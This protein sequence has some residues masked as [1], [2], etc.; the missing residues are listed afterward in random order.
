MK[1]GVITVF[2]AC[3]MALLLAFEMVV[4]ESAR[5]AG[6]RYLERQAGEA[7]AEG[8]L[9]GYNRPLFDTFGLL[10]YEGGC[11]Q[12]ELNTEAMEAAF[13]SIY[14]ENRTP[15]PSLVGGSLFSLTTAAVTLTEVTAAPDYS[16]AVLIE[17]AL[18]YYP[19]EAAGSVLAMI[20]EQLGL[21]EKGE[22]FRDDVETVE[23][24]EAFRDPAA[25]EPAAEAMAFS[26]VPQRG[27]P[28]LLREEDTGAESEVP[29]YDRERYDEA[30]ENSPIGSAETVKAGGWLNL[31]I[32]S[33]KAISAITFDT[34]LFPSE[35]SVDDR[36][37]QGDTL[38]NPVKKA[39]FNEYVLSMFSDY[40]G[41]KRAGGSAYEVEY[42]LFG[43]SSE[44][45]NLSACLNRIMW[46]REAMNIAFLYSDAGK[47]ETALAA[48]EVIAGWSGLPWLVAV[49]QAAL[50]ASWAYAEALL[51]TRTLLEGKRV[52]LLHNS[53]TWTLSLEGVTHFF[54]GG[55]VEKADTA[56][57][58]SYRDY[59]RVLLYCGNL[60]T[61]AY[62]TMDMIQYHFLPSNP[63]FRMANAVQSVS[64]RTTAVTTPLFSALP[65]VSAFLSRS[66]GS[67]YLITDTYSA[68]YGG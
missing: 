19:Y 27:I 68:D 47:R 53:G 26:H 17:N 60:S 44:R 30:V 20:L 9:A 1:K 11:G 14:E 54:S 6:L 37:P 39:L 63:Y 28:L 56:G 13:R 57:G 61:T 52:P 49:T 12:A 21:I 10:F 48:A 7:A 22:A 15:G 3:A 55:A 29:D 67:V 18:A 5:T 32:P 42:I 58:M 2:L 35:I 38:V 64:V 65:V 24:T 50:I 43:H 62:R 34:A 59:L 23:N 51:D 8:L 66:G 46:I 36:P 25:G 45:D 41:K 4:L 31:V 16:G 40:L 33:G